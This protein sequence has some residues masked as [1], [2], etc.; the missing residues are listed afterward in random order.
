MTTTT[1]GGWLVHVLRE[2]NGA[3]SLEEALHV[4]L[5]SMKDYFPCQSVAVMLID[6]DTKELRIKTSR[7][8]SYTYAKKFH[9]DGPGATAESVVLEQNPLLLNDLDT[10]SSVY[11][12]L[13]LEHD[14]TSAVL[15][16][17]IKNQRGI[18][19]VFS[20][21]AGQDKFNESDLLHL[22][23]VGYLIGNMIEKFE[24][25]QHGKKLSTIDDASQALQ[26]KAFVPEFVTELERGEE[27]DYPVM[28]A[29]LSVDAFRGYVETYGIDQAHGLLAEVVKATNNVIRDM[30][31]LARFGADE[32]VLCLSGVQPGE[33]REFLDKITKMVA[34]KAIGQGD[35]E[36]TLTVGAI[37]IPPGVKGSHLR[38][39]LAAVG[40]ALVRA[41]GGD[42]GSI[43]V[44]EFQIKSA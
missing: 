19:Y 31:I 37:T 5:D 9:R 16:P 8:I 35:E 36:I 17:I 40:K 14:F 30:D 28:L 2:A 24:L 39:I 7:N 34:E 3:L 38:D 4:I 13:K 1:L 42:D 20:D 11:K 41:K 44:D 26:Y 15:A 22:Q 27:H 23:V 6:E 25:I 21:R 12:D 29:L 43:V 10:E 33:G 32:F 18:G